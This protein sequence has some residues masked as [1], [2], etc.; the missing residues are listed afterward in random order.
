MVIFFSNILL[1]LEHGGFLHHLVSFWI[2]FL[3]F[4]VFVIEVPHLLSEIRYV[5]IV[6]GDIVN[7]SASFI[8]SQHLCHWFIDSLLSFVC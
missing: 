3:S 5:C 4:K 8:S 7:G 2:S 1:V 6:T